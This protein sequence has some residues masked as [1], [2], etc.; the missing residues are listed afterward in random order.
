MASGTRFALL[1]L[2]ALCGC[3][4]AEGSCA[5]VD[6]AAGSY[7][8]AIATA[9]CTENALWHTPFID[10]QGRLASMTV[11]EVET[12]PL[13]DGST[14]A[15]TRVAEYWRGSGLMPEMASYP[16]AGECVRA[17]PDAYPSPT[18]RAF[19]ADRPWSAAFVSWVLVKSRLPG[20]R[21]AASHLDYVRDAWHAKG[22]P[23]VLT[24]P[25]RES[26]A[27]GDLLCFIRGNGAPRGLAGLKAFLSSGKPGGLPMHCDIVVGRA[28]GGQDLYLVGGNVLQGATLRILALNRAG[29]LWSLPRGSTA[30]CA[31]GNQG[32]C[33]FN[34]QDWAAL[35]KLKPQ[36]ELE[37]LAGR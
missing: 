32:A 35:L 13:A 9:A 28:R 31:P 29:R 26:P 34:R 8:A 30:A 17:T 36:A 27:A 25:D 15:W 23:Y 24:D 16:G 5:T 33:S 37:K 19:L 11:S 21:P 7:A 2:L 14:P 22:S 6:A 20:F 18:C 12:A 4:K 3:A 10:A 1:L